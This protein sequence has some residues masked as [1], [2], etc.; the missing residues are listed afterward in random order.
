MQQI[1]IFNFLEV[2]QQHILDVVDKIIYFC[3]NLKGFLAVKEF[4]KPV[5]IW[6]SYRHKKVV[7]FCDTV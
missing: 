3:R 2:V 6:G 7:C 5:K 1:W 4:L